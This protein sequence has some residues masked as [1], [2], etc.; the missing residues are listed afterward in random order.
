LK[1][2]RR[3]KKL[4]KTTFRRLMGLYKK[5]RQKVFLEV[6]IIYLPAS[7]TLKDP[8]GLGQGT[9]DAKGIKSLPGASKVVRIGLYKMG[10]DAI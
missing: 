4:A 9:R 7:K 2:K 5:G 8:T 3:I 1:V 10:W 6:G